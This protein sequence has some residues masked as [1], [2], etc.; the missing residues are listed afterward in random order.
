VAIKM[1]SSG[2]LDLVIHDEP[3]LNEASGVLHD[4]VFSEESC[5]YDE[6]N[7]CFCLRLWREMPE[8]YRLERL[9]LFLNRVSFKRSACQ[10]IVRQVNQ[11]TLR[12]SDKLDWHSLFC[13]RYYRDRRLLVFQ[14]EGAIT[15]ELSVEKLDCQLTDTGETDWKQYGYSFISFGRTRRSQPFQSAGD[16]KGGSL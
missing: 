16:D 5:T 11:V 2:L 9:F 3:T 12:V 1:Q 4:A 7:R 14:T 10:L 8:V 15:L 13:L 6:K